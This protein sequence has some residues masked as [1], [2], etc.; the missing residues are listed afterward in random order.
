MTDAHVAPQA[1]SRPPGR[2]SGARLTGGRPARRRRAGRAHLLSSPTTSAGTGWSGGNYTSLEEGA[3]CALPT[4]VPPIDRS[5]DL[6]PEREA[7]TPVKEIPAT[8]TSTWRSRTASAPMTPPLRGARGGRRGGRVMYRFAG[9]A[10]PFQPAD[11]QLRVDHPGGPAGGDSGWAGTER[12]SHRLFRE[13]GGVCY[14]PA[15]G[16]HPPTRERGGETLDSNRDDHQRVTVLAGGLGALLG[17]RLPERVRET[18]IAGLGRV[19][20][21]VGWTWRR[22]GERPRRPGERARG[23][24]LGEWWRS[25]WPPSAS[26][27]PG[28]LSGA[29]RH[30]P[31]AFQRGVHHRQPGVLRADDDPG[32]PGGWP[33][34][35]YSRWPR[36]C[37]TA[38]PRW[39]LPRRWGSGGVL[40]DHR[41]RLP[42]G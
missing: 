38:L 13:T 20:I 14:F 22:D 11:G 42:G 33:T 6:P 35:D 24:L 30:Q 26:D 3:L 15:H 10:H 18:V 19:T 17:G 9:R 12:C 40:G 37:W 36:P 25:T 2:R 41:G 16:R 32:L 39:P 23:A 7:L 28:P 4:T 5:S 1:L 21:L 34:G 31:G 27:W 29:P 8:D